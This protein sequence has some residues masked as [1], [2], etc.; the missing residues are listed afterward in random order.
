ML[1]IPFVLPENGFL[2]AFFLTFEVVFPDFGVG[3]W[4]RLF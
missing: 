3:N 4:W 2:N 1:F